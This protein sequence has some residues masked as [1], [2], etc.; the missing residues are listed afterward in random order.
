[1]ESGQSFPHCVRIN[2]Y[3]NGQDNAW[4]DEVYR[5]ILQVFGTPGHKF[6][7][8]P[9]E[10]YMEFLFKSKKD[11]TMCKLLLSDRL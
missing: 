9:F 3:S 10:D 6:L 4:W 1:M 5:M 8:N 2:W 11:A 7:Y